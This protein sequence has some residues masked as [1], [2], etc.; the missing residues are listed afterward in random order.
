MAL[1]KADSDNGSGRI[2]TELSAAMPISADRSQQGLVSDNQLIINNVWETRILPQGP[3]QH[4]A[5]DA[6]LTATTNGKLVG[7]QGTRLGIY[8]LDETGAAPR[9]GQITHT[10]G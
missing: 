3:G 6:G 8:T 7:I 10:L 5:A 9:A 2:S 1:D 4:E